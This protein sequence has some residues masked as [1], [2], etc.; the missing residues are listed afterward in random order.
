[1]NK[2]VIISTLLAGATF[3]VALAQQNDQRLNRAI[4]D[5]KY[6]KQVVQ[7][8]PGFKQLLERRKN[9]VAQWNAIPT[10]ALQ[11]IT[12]KAFAVA[13][14]RAGTRHVIIREHQYLNDSG[15]NNGG[16]DLGIGTPDHVAAAI[17]GDLI[18]SYLTQA[19]IKGIAIDSLAINI[20]QT[21]QSIKDWGLDYTIYIDSP[22]SDETLESLRLLAEQHSP[23][24][25]FSI[26]A[27]NVNTVVEYSKSAENLVIPPTYQPGL[28]EFIEW[29]TKK[30]EANRKL[31]EN[32]QKPDFSKFGGYHY[33]YPYSRA[34]EFTPFKTESFL[35]PDGPSAFINPST[36][37]VVLQ[38]RHHRVYQD[39][40]I[41][42]G[43]NDLGPTGIESHIGLLGSCFTHVAEGTAARN[44]IPLDTLKVSLTAQFDP[45]SGRQ[46]FTQTPLYPTDIKMRVVVSSPREEAVIRQLVADTEKGCPIYNLVVNAQKITGRVERVIAKNK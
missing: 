10:E 20:K 24:Y 16:F 7:S 31:R 11:P 41:I 1:M 12:I 27:H 39:H 38:V 33:D 9:A 14:Q 34:N 45:R 46:G 6:F 17:A 2:K 23:L 18:D 43:G 40:P 25:Q 13:E 44:R 22:V 15:Y 28:R 8:A 36:G 21:K 4:T 29:E 19:A 37:V 42:F 35:T 26:R 32:K 3:S 5:A 30:G